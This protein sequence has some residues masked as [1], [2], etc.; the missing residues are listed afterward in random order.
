MRH[1]KAHP[2]ASPDVEAA[3]PAALAAKG[4]LPGDLAARAERRAE[5][6]TGMLV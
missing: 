2:G 3:H 4:S 6:S 1:W 5:E